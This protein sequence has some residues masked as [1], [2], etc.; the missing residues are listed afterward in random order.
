MWAPKEVGLL[1]ITLL[2]PRCLL[3]T[4]GSGDEAQLTWPPEPQACAHSKAPGSGPQPR[5]CAWRTSGQG[6][7]NAM[8][9]GTT[10]HPGLG[11]ENREV[12]AG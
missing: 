7:G 6:P 8:G 4:E 2:P 5:P 3:P 11:K 12:F 9:A 1:T 10:T